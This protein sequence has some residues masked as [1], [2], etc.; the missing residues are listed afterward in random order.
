VTQL[1][2]S[3]FSGARPARPPLDIDTLVR[4]VLLAAVFLLL[5]VTISPFATLADQQEATDAG[6]LVNQLA[7]SLLF[8]FLA[9][10]CFAHQPRRLLLLVRP[11]LIATV[12]WFAFTVVTS[13]DPSLSAR[14]LV[15]TL[16]AMGIAAMAMLVPKNI[17]HFGDV[18]AAV[19]LIVLTLSYLGV[20]L[21]PSVSIHQATDAIEPELAGDWRG[22]FGHKNGAGE[23]MVM[24]AFIGLL[25]ARTR[26][27]GLGALI[28]VLSVI[29]LAFAR[30][31]TSIAMLPVALLVSVILHHIRRPALGVTLALLGVV[32]FNILSIGSLYFEPIRDLLDLLLTDSTF[33]GR[34]DV[35]QF[36][37]DHLR[38]RPITGYGF[39][40][41]WGT[42]EVVHGM[43]DD[44]SWANMAGHAHNGYLDLALTVGYPGAALAVLW[45]VVLPLVDFYR[46][47]RTLATAPLEM[48]FLRVSLF[49]AYASCFESILGQEG[50]A[51]LF[52][53]AATFGLRLLAV[54]RPTP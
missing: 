49:T 38:E 11:V 12:A 16:V 41:F 21:A 50:A 42:P 28:V 29:F 23:A 2:L 30:S 53:F 25:V 51:M 47:P 52:L 43:G 3:D 22:V 1:D 45:L 19:A 9:A 32:I 39:G 35:W 46:A 54:S 5:W 37:L 33:T 6:S 44:S 40:A 15:F 18:M 27:R 24:F 13:W 8:L 4:T 34:A 26:S 36:A 14:R 48:L 31:K 7:Y 10:W 20:F 17:R